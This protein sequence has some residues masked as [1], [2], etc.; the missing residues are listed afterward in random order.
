MLAL[1]ILA[2][3]SK[4]TLFFFFKSVIFANSSSAQRSSQEMTAWALRIKRADAGRFFFIREG[5]VCEKVSVWG[6]SEGGSAQG[7]IEGSRGQGAREGRSWQDAR[8]GRKR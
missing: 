5:R 1:G 7:A 3:I 6:V 8:E 4:S 2:S